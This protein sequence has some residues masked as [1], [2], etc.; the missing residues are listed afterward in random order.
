MH[1]ELAIIIMHAD[2]VAH[3]CL[4]CSLPAAHDA[5][6]DNTCN[7]P[8]TKHRTNHQPMPRQQQY[9]CRLLQ[10][11]FCCQCCLVPG[12]DLDYIQTWHLTGTRF[13]TCK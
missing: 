7:S 13:S 3:N 1:A 10:Q 2:I 6:P 11:L 5:C 12:S 9:C 8:T 4:F